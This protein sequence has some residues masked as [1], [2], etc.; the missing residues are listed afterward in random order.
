[1]KKSVEHLPEEKRKEIE[2]IVSTIKE[3][4]DDVEMMILF[5]SYARGDYKVEDDLKPDRRSGHVSD[6]DILVVTK[7]KGTV[8]KRDLWDALSRKCNKKK[9]S[10]Q[11]RLIAHDILKL[12]TRLA[13]GD[14]FF[15]DI[16]KEGCVV[17]DSGNF[18]LADERELTAE[19]R[20]RIAQDHF[21][22]WFERAREFWGSYQDNFKAKRTNIAVFDLHQTTESCY[23]SILLV[24]T[25]YN[26]NEHLL[27]LLS[28]M[29]VAQDDSF[30]EI[31]P[32]ETTEERHRFDLLDDAYIG[33]RYDPD[34]RISKDDIRL[35]A[36]S[37]ET[38]LAL[39]ETVCRKKIRN[40]IQ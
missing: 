9:L 19:E 39:T 27:D 14:Y 17:Y 36:E 40:F 3:S 26:P 10:A 16:K 21:D 6:Y 18:E 20:Q 22:H 5:G 33:A 25:N 34:Y 32:R 23:K 38:L 12:N 2:S 13:E 8:E 29:V 30:S 35:L 7:D 31:F 37:V 24:Y 11:T 1:M 28:D 15:S 4:C